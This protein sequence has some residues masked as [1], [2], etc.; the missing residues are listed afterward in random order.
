MEGC[1]DEDDSPPGGGVRR[2]VGVL[3]GGNEEVGEGGFQ[4][5]E[6]AEGIDLENGAEGIRREA[7]DG[8]EEVS[9]SASA[10]ISVSICERELGAWCVEITY[11]T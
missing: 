2:D 3:G 1:R 8:S 6:G 11:M 9:G 5:V 7:G 4:G 10:M